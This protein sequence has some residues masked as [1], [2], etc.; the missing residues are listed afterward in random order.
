MINFAWI[1]R[2]LAHPKKI[3]LEKMTKLGIFHIAY[4]ATFQ[5]TSSSFSFR[6]VS[7]FIHH[8]EGKGRLGQV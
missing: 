8:R 2:G 4:Q 1:N 7:R 5:K 3:I 6:P